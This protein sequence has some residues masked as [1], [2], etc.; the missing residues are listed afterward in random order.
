MI[1]D[2]VSNA[3][4]V[5]SA[6]LAAVA[7]VISILSLRHARRSADAAE[8]SAAAAARSAAA[9]ESAA[10]TDRQRLELEQADR[11]ETALKEA[12]SQR[13]ANVRLV[14]RRT[15][16]F[17]TAEE[18]IYDYELVAINDG[19]CDAKDFV[20]STPTCNGLNVGDMP[21]LIEF[22]AKADGTRHLLAGRDVVMPMNSAG[23]HT[24][25][26]IADVQASWTDGNGSHRQTLRAQRGNW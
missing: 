10:N 20:L 9:G 22:E 7:A 8:A 3:V 5:A 18:D 24:S 13:A 25:F 2:I 4:A 15:L 14:T 26:D 16:R 21:A 19:P 6:T 17:S 12:L 11:N 1:A 23:A